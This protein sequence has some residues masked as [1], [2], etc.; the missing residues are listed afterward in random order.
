MSYSIA[1]AAA[2]ADCYLA[3]DVPFILHGDPG[4]G[5]SD[6]I[7]K[8]ARRRFD[9]RV[10]DFRASNRDAVDLMGVPS[11]EGGLTVWNIPAELPNAARHGERGILFLDEMNRGTAQTQAG[12]LS[13]SLDRFVG[14]YDMRVSAPGWRIA[15]ACNVK[16]MARMDPAN[17]N[18]FAHI[19]VAPDVESWIDWA[20][21]TDTK[22]VALAPD[23]YLDTLEARA[24]A[25]V[26][27]P[28]V[29]VAF[30]RLKPDQLHAMPSG[31]DIRA[32]PSPRS[33]AMAARF[34]DAPESLRLAL[35]AGCVGEVA[36]VALEAFIL[37]YRSLPTLAEILADPT[38]AKL[39]SAS[40]IAAQHL[41]SAVLSRKADRKTWPAIATYAARLIPELEVLTFTDA[42]KRAPELVE[43]H[44]YVAFQVRRQ[45]ELN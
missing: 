2:L 43:T 38:G 20:C 25:P 5:K 32:F 34:V 27:I 12:L 4:L 9:G 14:A 45:A 37:T 28:P 24:A 15:S 1:F 6:A 42:V 30:M 23:S 17:A 41:L 29:M 3:A 22:S 8:A 13:L 26:E 31:G 33:W 44:E 7:R 19:E 36:A 21:G 16:G 10:V 40:E 11:V 18:R 35:I 39:P